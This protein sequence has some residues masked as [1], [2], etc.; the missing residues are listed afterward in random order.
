M[1]ENEIYINKKKTEYFFYRYTS[2]IFMK[3]KWNEMKEAEG[4]KN[5]CGLLG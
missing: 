1:E 2:I 4:I 5:S 3:K